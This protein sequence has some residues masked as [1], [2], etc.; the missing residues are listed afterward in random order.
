MMKVWIFA[1]LAIL[2]IWSAIFF[3]ARQADIIQRR[4]RQAFALLRLQDRALLMGESAVTRDAA[5]LAE[6]FD[7][8]QWLVTLPTATDTPAIFETLYG[9]PPSDLSVTSARELLNTSRVGSGAVETTA[10]NTRPLW[11]GFRK[12]MTRMWI[13]GQDPENSKTRFSEWTP[14]A[15]Q[16]GGGLSTLVIIFTLVL[17]LVGLR[18]KSPRLKDPKAAT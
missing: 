6:I 18:K 5:D 2:T 9:K 10:L 3:T 13:L 12:G 11:I 17:Q 14:V 8:G 7:K 1:T 16:V 4:D 15:T